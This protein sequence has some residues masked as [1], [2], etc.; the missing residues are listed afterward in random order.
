MEDR[1]HRKILLDRLYDVYGPLLTDRQQEV[2]VLHH[3]RDLSLAEIA[4]TM[5]MSRQGVHDLFQRAR[6]R[7]EELEKRLGCLERESRLTDALVRLDACCANAGVKLPRQ[8]A[9]DLR[10]LVDGEE[11]GETVRRHV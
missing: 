9:E 5:D 7:L 4:E 1:L 10:V 2:F 6:D 8:L 11:T 3:E